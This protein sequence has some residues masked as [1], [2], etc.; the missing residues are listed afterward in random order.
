MTWPAGSTREPTCSRCRRGSSRRGQAQMIALRYGTPPIVHRTGGLADTVVDETTHPGHGTGFAFEHATV[1][2]LVWAC[3][4]AI[5]FRGD[6]ARRERG[7][8]CS[9]GR[10]QST[11]TGRARPRPGMSRRIVGLSR[12][13][14]AC[15]SR[16]R[17]CDRGRARGA[18][19]ARMLSAALGRSSRV[20]ALESGARSES[21]LATSPI[22]A[23]SRGRCH[24]AR[25]CQSLA[26]C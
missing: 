14:V 10:W 18:V 6:G 12:C 21:A 9:I 25:R 19:M 8:R 15:S 22:D 3:D 23:K 5:A 2:G 24:L 7:R 11:S 20:T 17:R 13:A 4:A 16:R 26:S 1:E